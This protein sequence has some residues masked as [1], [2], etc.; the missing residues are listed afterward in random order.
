MFNGKKREFR[1]SG[2]VYLPEGFTL[3]AGDLLIESASFKEANQCFAVRFCNK[4]PC[5]DLVCF[6]E[7]ASFFYCL[8]LFV[9]LLMHSSSIPTLFTAVLRHT[10]FSND[11]RSSV[12]RDML[13]SFVLQTNYKCL[14]KNLCV[15]I[16]V[17]QI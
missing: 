4:V 1:F 8:V 2:L 17:S 10:C 6:S 12:I 5:C 15:L 9:F 14:G 7:K 3:I 13:V 16:S 11:R